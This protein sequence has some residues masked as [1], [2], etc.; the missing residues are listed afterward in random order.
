MN[1]RLD[2]TALLP[3]LADIE[4]AAQVVYGDFA[5]PPQD[6][7]GLLSQRLGTDC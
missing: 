7:W 1:T 3:T 5:A 2:P 6:R 4:A